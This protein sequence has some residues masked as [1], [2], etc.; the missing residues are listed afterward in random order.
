MLFFKDNPNVHIQ[1]LKDNV[2]KS[3]AV[4]LGLLLAKELDIDFIG[5]LDSDGAFREKDVLES[6]LI[7]GQK[8]L[9][10]ET[11]M[12]S[13]ARVSL[14]G[15]NIDRKKYRHFV[16]RVVS[17]IL[18]IRSNIVFYDSQSGFKVFSKEFLQQIDLGST[19]KTRWFLDWEIIL[20]SSR[21]VN[22]VELPVQNWK[23]VSGSKISP[24]N[25]ISI[26]K[27]LIL[28]KVMQLK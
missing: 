16:G 10:T 22:I 5:Y 19:F 11:D 6:L 15:S 13:L 28:I 3:N 27:E 8:Y 18:S 12:L 1:K 24:V 23:D 26:I 2:G 17:T 21:I 14:A 20:R 7:F 25:F 4:R 9:Q